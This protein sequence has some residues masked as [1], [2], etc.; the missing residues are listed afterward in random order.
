VV[1]ITR[2][3]MQFVHH[4]VTALIPPCASPW[5]HSCVTESSLKTETTSDYL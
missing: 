2:N 3:P 1:H 4:S 5:S